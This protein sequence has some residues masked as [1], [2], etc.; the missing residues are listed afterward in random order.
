MRPLLITALGRTISAAPLGRREDDIEVRRVPA[1][2]TAASLD[3]ERPTVI[4]LDRALIASSGA[5]HAALA[6]LAA[7]AALVGIGDPGELEPGPDFPHDLLT[8]Y[9]AVDAPIG[10]PLATPRGG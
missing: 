2:P 9:A 1:L 10:S 3:R 6:E 8:G 7:R 5:E 4:A